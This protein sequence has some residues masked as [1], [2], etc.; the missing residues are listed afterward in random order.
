MCAMLTILSNY[1]TATEKFSP[2]RGSYWYV[3]PFNLSKEHLMLSFLA[4]NG[5][6]AQ[7]GV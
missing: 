7:R 3:T 4:V 6:L 1:S 5:V 2:A